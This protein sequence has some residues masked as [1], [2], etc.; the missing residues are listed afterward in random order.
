[1]LQ[2]RGVREARL[3][4]TASNSAAVDLYQETGYEIAR[5]EMTKRV[6]R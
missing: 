1:F 5:H 4:V 3:T 6:L 2:E